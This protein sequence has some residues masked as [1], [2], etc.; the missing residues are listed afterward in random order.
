[1]S[2]VLALGALV[3]A[4]VLFKY[5]NNKYKV[6]DGFDTDVKEYAPVNPEAGPQNNL[7]RVP[8]NVESSSTTNPS[9][10]L[11]APTNKVGA[12]VNADLKNINLLSAGANS[13]INTVG[14]TLRNP[15]LTIRAEPVIQKVA[16]GPWN[17]T[18]IEADTNRRGFDI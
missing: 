1:M 2:I 17:M 4:A 6:F 9:D 18:T 10:L 11:P 16:T 14:G 7:T 15:N 3:V 5:S 12:A 13:G 8:K